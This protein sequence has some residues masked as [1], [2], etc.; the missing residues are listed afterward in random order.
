M[1][2]KAA[3]FETQC[4]RSK[5]W[6]LCWL[7]QY[8]ELFSAGGGEGKRKKILDPDTVL[9]L[10]TP[11]QNWHCNMCNWWGKSPTSLYE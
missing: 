9:C 11:L 10:D 3:F 8:S 7:Y 5:A 6:T 4:S 1:N 2:R